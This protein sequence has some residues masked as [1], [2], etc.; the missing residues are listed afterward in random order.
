MTS[1][2]TLSQAK[3]FGLQLN[4]KNS[5]GVKFSENKYIV[6]PLYIGST[7]EAFSVIFTHHAP[8]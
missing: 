5:R 7:T 3:M 4:T 2:D 1:A 6:R 8:Y